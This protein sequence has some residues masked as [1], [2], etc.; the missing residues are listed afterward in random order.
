MGFSQQ[1]LGIAWIT[2][3]N[4]AIEFVDLSINRWRTLPAEKYADG[5]VPPD[6]ERFLQFYK[7]F[8]PEWVITYDDLARFFII[9]ENELATA[10]GLIVLDE[11]RFV[12]ARMGELPKVYFEERVDPPPPEPDT[13]ASECER[14]IAALENIQS[15]PSAEEIRQIVTEVI[16]PLGFEILQQGNYIRQEIKPAARDAGLAASALFPGQAPEERRRSV[17]QE[18]FAIWN[19]PKSFPESLVQKFDNKGNPVKP[20]TKT[21]NNLM[22]FFEWVV[23]VFE[24]VLGEFPTSIEFVTSKEEKPVLDDEGNPVLDADGNPETKLEVKKEVVRFP[25]LAE[26]LSEIA[27]LVYQ[28]YTNTEKLIELSSKTLIEAGSTKS[29]CTKNFYHLKAVERFTGMV[30][31]QKTK[32]IPLLFTAGQKNL[33]GFSKSSKAEID[34]IEWNNE[35]DI[36][37]KEI[38][39]E[40]LFAAKIIRGVYWQALPNDTESA[41][42]RIKEIIRQEV[43]F[44]EKLTQRSIKNEQESYRKIERAFTSEAGIGDTTDY[45]GGTLENTVEIR[46]ITKA[47]D[48]SEE[49]EP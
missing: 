37:L 14:L 42:A 27:P 46:Q 33:L 26:I 6:L 9:P 34:I 1:P 41:A 43:N 16:Q 24:E 12:R 23:L 15:I 3:L 39:Q 36:G 38:L 28:S 8:M 25:N 13:D 20:G 18:F 5:I 19:F 17:F 35:K 11:L 45:W 4:R 30:T 2:A 29:I 40:L 10:T 44:D 31:Q 32:K 21:V 22:D 47:P 48:N 49:E 7:Q